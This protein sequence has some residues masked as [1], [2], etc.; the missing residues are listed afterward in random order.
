MKAQETLEKLLK[1]IE[2]AKTIKDFKNDNTHHI[3]NIVAYY[4]MLKKESPD[5]QYF[6]AA[7]AAIMSLNGT[8]PELS[9]L[10][11][12]LLNKK[13]KNQENTIHKKGK[14]VINNF[15]ELLRAIQSTITEHRSQKSSGM[16]DTYELEQ[17]INSLRIYQNALTKYKDRLNP[18]HIAELQALIEQ[19]IMGAN[20]IIEYDNSI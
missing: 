9:N 16:Q 6:K 14:P 10:V 8:K 11:Q 1:E 15:N 3:T 7:T 2:Q 4:N 13:E 19:E 17:Y 18:K 5:S 12:V 20:D